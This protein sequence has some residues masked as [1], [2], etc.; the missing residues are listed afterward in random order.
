M[1]KEVGLP[2]EPQ[3]D[4]ARQ[5]REQAA[6]TLERAHH[7]VAANGDSLARLCAAGVLRVRPVG[8]VIA[9][10]A[11]H[12]RSDGSFPLL[13]A[14]SLAAFG[15]GKHGAESRSPLLGTLEGLS[16]LA[17]FHAFDG[18]CVERAVAYLSRVQERDGSWSPDAGADPEQ[19]LWCTGLLAGSLGRSAVV[20]ARVLDA[21]A[22]F[23]A[24][25]WS[26]E[27][28]ET[29]QWP[30]LA[31]FAHCFS[32][33][34]H[35]QSDAALQWCGRAL[36]RAYRSGR[37]DALAAA[38]LLLCCGAAGLPAFG[39][40]AGELVDALA[41]EQA[42]DGSFATPVSGD[43]YTRLAPTLDAMQALVT[44]CAAF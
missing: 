14:S 42:G 30:A 20:R 39:I 4:P 44:L 40:G 13:S 36:E 17:D 7:F 9:G 25:R 10:I 3:S 28:V 29:G 21:A 38:R 31:C 32:N 34:P 2:S 5:R 1:P 18:E 22:A 24:E 27:R 26:P 33:L 19:R 35:E 43:L 8:D 37:I 41:G 16:L 11:S 15:F 23:V 12:Q 6:T